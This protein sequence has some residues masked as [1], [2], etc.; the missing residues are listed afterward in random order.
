MVFRLNIVNLGCAT[1][2]YD[3]KFK[4]V[5][6]QTGPGG[7]ETIGTDVHG[8]MK[9]GYRATFT[10]TL[11]TNPTWPTHGNVG[12]VDYGC[13]I[14]GATC[15]YVSWTD[16]Y[17]TGVASFDQ[18]WWG[19]ITIRSTRPEHGSRKPTVYW[20]ATK[21]EVLRFVFCFSVK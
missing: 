20:V 6:G 21:H 16:Q 9:G 17:F 1:V 8:D 7:K 4:A 18:P 5:A 3:G 19:A 12:T 11:L 15:H 13:D 14:T 2:T 10:G